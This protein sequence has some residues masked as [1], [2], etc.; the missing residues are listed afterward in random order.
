MNR[1]VLR[2]AIVLIASG[3]LLA[4]GLGPA[5]AGDDHHEADQTVKVVGDGHSVD[6]S[7]DT[8]E[9]GSI[10]FEVS[11]T[12]PATM[13]GGGSQITLFRLRPNK[14]LDNF[15]T[16]L[17]EEFSQTPATAAAGTRGLDET[18]VFRGLA[19]VVPDYPETV[20]ESLNPGTYYLLDLSTPPA[21]GRPALT[22]LH[23]NSDGQHHS[24][25]T[26]DLTVW[27][28]NERFDAPATWPHEGTYTFT[29]EDDTLHFMLI[30]PVKAGTTDDQVQAALNDPTLT[31]P[32]DFAVE[33]PSGGNDVVS[34]GYSLQVTYDLPAGTYVLLCFVADEETG[35]PHAVMGMHKVVVLE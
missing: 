11:S 17:T 12:N 10:S 6:I 3:G 20:T 27:A 16:H 7:T 24:D 18:A 30:L 5:V 13:D 31:G 21:S 9:A 25:V 4:G 2:T 22:T 29:N 35:M 34:P 28:A 14:S 19:D 1:S 33:G 26:S 15:F 8:V 32:P 23:V